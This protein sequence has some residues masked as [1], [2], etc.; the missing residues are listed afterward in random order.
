MPRYPDPYRHPAGKKKRT[1]APKQS[2]A[3]PQPKKQPVRARSAQ[4]PPV[5]KQQPVKKA[6]V[7]QQTRR[8]Y[9]S[10]L[11]YLWIA[12]AFPELVLHL[13]TA[14]SSELLVNSGLLLGAVFAAV[15]A[16]VMFFLCTS[17]SKGLNRLLT[18]LYSALAFL[19]CA[20]QLVYY[21]IFGTFY[22]F[23]SMTN[24]GAA[25]QFGAT[26]AS[27]VTKNLVTLLL[28]AVPLLTMLLGGRRRYYFQRRRPLMPKL[29]VLLAAVVIH[30]AAVSALPMFGGTDDTSA[31]GLYHN[32]SDAYLGVNRLG[33][34]TAFR[35]DMMRTITG[36][37]AEGSIDL[38]EPVPVETEPPE[39]HQFLTPEEPAQ[40]EPQTTTPSVPETT[41]PPET[42]EPPITYDTSPNVLSI[43]FDSLIA[44]EDDKT[45]KEVHQYFAARTPSNKNEKTGMFEG[46]NLI[47]ITAEAFSHLAVSEELTP[48]LYMMMNEGFRFTNYYVP[49]WGV[50]T[51]DGEYAHLTG[52]IPKDGVWSFK[53]SAGNLMPLT[54]NQQLLGLGYNSYAY[55][56]HT[57]TYYSRDKYLTNL[58]YNYKGLGNGLEV[59]KTWPE[60]DVE[61]VDLSTAD[62][63]GSEPFSVYYMSISGHREFTFGGN[64]IAAKNKEHVADLPYS[65]NVRAYL[66]TQLELEWSMGLLLQRLEEAGVLQNTVIVLTAD[67]YPNGL[68]PEEL[69]E[70]LGHTP[71]GNFEIY[72]N[73]AFIWKPG[74]TPETIDEPASHLD[75]L[76]TLSNLFGLEFDS[77]LYMGRDVFSDAPP[78]VMFRNRSWITDEAQY[79]SQT[80]KAEFYG[81]AGSDDAYVKAINSEVGNR[82]AV[83]TRILEND[84]WRILFGE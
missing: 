39:E 36:S 57:Y 66:A 5:K 26:I 32:A 53:R 4:K 41:A 62:F 56:G 82:F 31:Y 9:S 1:P 8:R 81:A 50:S 54:M 78:L 11:F 48:T 38:G 17:L 10:L 7:K 69:G 83:S 44:S 27:A 49:D 71:E 22:T 25:F 55:H 60:S 80:R 20:S 77:R 51:T 72:R 68:T 6:P 34:F 35:L 13:S 30:I 19:F 40:T 75:L 2:P 59:K 65:S 70:L 3:R 61:V 52:T 42:T 67:H 74:M 16:A 23:F 63:V 46:C 43:D 24:G 21:R 58:G 29:A 18:V 64:A 76:P 12:L 47:L 33:L 73:G 79:N 28:M 15:P 37:G 14:K 45:V 84:Y